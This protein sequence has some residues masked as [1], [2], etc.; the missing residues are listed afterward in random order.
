[1][2]VADNY[3]STL[4]EILKLIPKHFVDKGPY[5]KR[6][7]RLISSGLEYYDRTNENNMTLSILTG[8]NMVVKASGEYYSEIIQESIKKN[9]KKQLHYKYY[10][11]DDRIVEVYFGLMDA[12]IVN[13]QKYHDMMRLIISWAHICMKYA[14]KEC[15][16]R[17]NI[18]FYLTDFKKEMP[19]NNIIVL[20][21]HHV[22]TG[23]TTR[24]KENNETIIYR[25]E[26]WFKV[27]VHEMMHAFGFDISET[28]RN[29]ISTEIKKLFGIKSSM[30][31]EEAYVETWAR[32]INGAY[33]S[34]QSSE[35]ENDFEQLFLFSMEVE[36]LYA[37]IKAQQVLNYMHLS[38]DS[39][40]T[41]GNRVAYSLY[42]ER[43]NVFAY[44]ILVAIFMNDPYDFMR[45]CNKINRK[46]LRF[47]NTIKAVK[48]LEKYIKALH[49]HPDFLENIRKKYRSK[50]RGLRMSL[51]EVN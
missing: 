21:R 22:N 20:D 2:E 33:A 14:F 34:I 1:M 44:Y 37:T 28:Y 5:S 16:K 40:I 15:S 3:K 41:K 23:V 32:I 24:C 25:K 27:Y 7:Y 9:I 29:T 50:N 19:N 26:E 49:L 11:S 30:R 39:L 8:E 10:F 43:T 48:E 36:R 45:L 6:L 51:I 38:Y 46:W 4:D 17:H 18:F 47:D 31:V 12:H 13:Y 35:N 42:R